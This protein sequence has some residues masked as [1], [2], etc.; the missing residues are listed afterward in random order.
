MSPERNED[1]VEPISIVFEIMRLWDKALALA[2][3]AH[4]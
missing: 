1:D 4:Q 3:T 2:E